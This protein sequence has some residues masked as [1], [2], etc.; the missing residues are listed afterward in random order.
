MLTEFARDHAFTIAWFGI[1]S[2][3]WFGWGQE[4]PPRSRRGWLG[5]G[6]AVGLIVAGI[7]G[8]AVFTRWS[9]RSALDGQYVWFGVVV[10][11]EVLLAAVGC[12][13]LARRGQGRWMA[14]WVAV[15]VA[16]HFLP[17]A[18]FLRDPSLAGLG[19]VQAIGLAVLVGR[20]RRTQ[21][22]TSWPVGPWMGVTLLVFAGISTAIFLATIGSPW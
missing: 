2:F 6:S 22:P 16:L 14:W 19:V 5:A 4:D 10:G 18:V 13:V 3:V 1:M 8:F 7:F 17:L 20:L 15:V 9:D 11:V 12:F 21:A